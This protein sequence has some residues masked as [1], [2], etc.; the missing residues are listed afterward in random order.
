MKKKICVS[1]GGNLGHVCAGH[2]A[3]TGDFEVSLLTRHPG[4][5]HPTLSIA[6]PSGLAPLVGRLSRISDNPH[7]VV[8]G[9]DFVLLCLPGYAIRPT[10]LAI[11]DHLPDGAAVGSVVCNTGFFFQALE[12]LPGNVPLFGLQRV[13]FISRIEEYGRSARLLGYKESLAMAVEHAPDREALRL[14][15]EKMFRTPVRLL[16]NHYEASLSNSN[17][18]LHPSRLYDLWHD[19]QEGTVYP[20]IPLFYEEWTENAAQLYIDMDNELQA[21]LALLPIDKGNNP[22]VLD[23]YQSTDAAS[24]AA[25]L[26]SI[27]AFKGI[28]SPMK[29]VEGGYVPDFASRY[30]TED[31]PYGLSFVRK[32]AAENGVPTPTMDRI[33]AWWHDHL[34]ASGH[35][36]LG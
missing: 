28:L 11:R 18:L 30:F 7:D 16:S 29:A 35:S 24:L 5:W 32:T 34:A 4:R 15:A 36:P 31:F 2:M 23:Y 22:S 8:S 10:L 26:R 1:G 21:L 19:W 33:F 6:R 27:E 17:P 20:R 12:L 9:A 25:K 14:D 3:A 13:P